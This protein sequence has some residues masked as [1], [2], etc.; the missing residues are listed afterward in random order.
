MDE[1]PTLTDLILGLSAVIAPWIVIAAV[2]VAL[3]GLLHS[4][5]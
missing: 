1:A 2:S 5:A 3:F 4:H